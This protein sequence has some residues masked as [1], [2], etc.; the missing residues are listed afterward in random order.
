VGILVSDAQFGNLARAA[1]G[2]IL[3]ALAAGLRVVKRTKSVVCVASST[4][5]LLLLSK[6]VGASETG[7]AKERR[8]KD[9]KTERPASSFMGTSLVAG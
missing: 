8:P 4:K 6:P 3:V 9:K 5:P 7:G 1:G 2:G